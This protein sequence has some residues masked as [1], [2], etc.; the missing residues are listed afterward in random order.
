MRTTRADDG[1]RRGPAAVRSEPLV[2]GIVSDTHLYRRARVMPQALLEGL[3]GV[4]LILHAGD[5]VEERVLQ[6]FARIA[7]VI[8]VRG[9][10]DPPELA[11]LLPAQRVV[12]VGKA[13]LGLVHG[14]TGPGRS[15]PERAWRTFLGQPV[16]AII[17]G[18]SHRPFLEVREGR[19]LFNPGSPTDRRR[20]PQPSFGLLTVSG[21]AV[22]ARHVFL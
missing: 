9:N 5:L 1:G 3:A 10:N 15:T 13:R 2:V 21:G 6:E 19:L 20:A 12:T 18:H 7:P 16:Q 4:H 17:F 22:T 8:A 11:D 14:H